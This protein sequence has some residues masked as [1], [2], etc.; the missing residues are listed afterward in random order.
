VLLAD[1]EYLIE[2]C[3]ELSQRCES[4]SQ[5]YADTINVMEAR[6]SLAQTERINRLTRLAFLF[7]PL[8]FISSFFKM[9]VDVFKNDP[10]PVTGLTF[11]LLDR[12]YSLQ[13]LFPGV[14]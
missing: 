7:I 12:K 10:V 4:I 9:N 13:K 11:L 14:S 1:H 8:S 6:K 3:S 5:I 2:R